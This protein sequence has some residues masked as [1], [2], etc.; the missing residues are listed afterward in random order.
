M[1]MKTLQTPCEKGRKRKMKDEKGEKA[2][3]K[4][5][6]EWQMATITASPSPWGEGGTA[7]GRD[8]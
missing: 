2:A 4:K 8:G 6:D 3:V 1:F 5:P 7:K